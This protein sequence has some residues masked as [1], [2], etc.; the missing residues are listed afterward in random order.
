[1]ST[2]DADSEYEDQDAEPTNTAPAGERPSDPGPIREAHE[3]EG[4]PAP[5]PDASSS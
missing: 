2:Q 5:G 4:D 3:H 1:M